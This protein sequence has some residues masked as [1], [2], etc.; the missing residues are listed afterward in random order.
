[1]KKVVVLVH[2]DVG[3]KARLLAAVDLTQ[4]LAGHLRCID[5]TPLPL[6]LNGGW[7][8]GP[9]L[10]EQSRIAADQRAWIERR[11]ASE[12]ISWD[13]Q[14][15]R[16]GFAESILAAAKTADIIVLSKKLADSTA[17][18]MMAITRSVVTRSQALVV[19]VD[20]A[21]RRFVITGPAL[22]AWDGSR[23]AM[24]A[25]R[26]ALPLLRFASKVDILQVGTLPRSAITVEDAATYLSLNEIRP[27]VVIGAGKDPV[28]AINR[29]AAETEAGYCVMG[30]FG[31]GRTHEA[32]LG[33][34]TRAMLC[35][36]TLPLVLGH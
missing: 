10:R 4:A 23:T 7:G 21:C 2:Q 22:I 3:Q 25:L 20:Q 31:S 29:A 12:S 17:P 28:T 15:A 14:E 9:T 26:R 19:A 34:V 13:L 35:S 8:Y 6:V 18:D 16:G 24:H 1:M 33:S 11:L 32:L 27:R 36:S 30:A 5:V